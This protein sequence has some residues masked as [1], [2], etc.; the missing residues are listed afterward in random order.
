MK[1]RGNIRTS[2]NSLDN[3]KKLRIQPNF[4]DIKFQVRL[5]LGQN[6]LFRMNHRNI[7]LNIFK[8]RLFLAEDWKKPELD[9]NHFIRL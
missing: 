5:I 3:K 9:H 8:T 2:E 7:N 6:I 4:Y 1:N